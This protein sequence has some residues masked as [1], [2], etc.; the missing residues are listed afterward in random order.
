LE[1]HA[2]LPDLKAL[3]EDWLG[4]LFR[5]YWFVCWLSL[6]CAAFFLVPTALPIYG[7]TLSSYYWV[8][9]VVQFSLFGLVYARAW[10][11]RDPLASFW[12]ATA[13][14]GLGTE[15]VYT[16]G[17]VA[18]LTIAFSLAEYIFIGAFGFACL[19]TLVLLERWAAEQR[20]SAHRGAESD[21]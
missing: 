11:D 13:S 1:G 14:A 16:S 10:F 19:L 18:L 17:T 6:A 5:P 15:L 2:A 3:E 8:L 20:V 9:P 7:R 4:R 21:S 12:L